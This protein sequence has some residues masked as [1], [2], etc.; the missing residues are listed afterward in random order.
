MN[1]R[2]PSKTEILFAVM[3][4]VLIIMSF[5]EI[6]SGQTPT[7]T[8]KPPGCEDCPDPNSVGC[9]INYPVCLQCWE[10]C[11]HPIA[12]PTPTPTATATPTNTPTPTPTPWVPPEWCEEI[13]CELRTTNAGTVYL[14]G[15]WAHE[16]PAQPGMRYTFQAPPQT[17][18]P[19]EVA[20][21]GPFEGCPIGYEWWYQP[22]D[23][24]KANAL[25]KSCGDTDRRY[26]RIFQDGFESG[27]TGRWSA[28][29]GG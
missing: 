14:I 2:R 19:G 27:N 22:P 9:A 20:R 13:E 6:A 10:N 17:L 28:T 18:E 11:G 8:P 25:V 23:F 1:G 21:P 29:I 7:P 3:I 24:S 5:C 15:V 12:T 26:P 16:D 4:L